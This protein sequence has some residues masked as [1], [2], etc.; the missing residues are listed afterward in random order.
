VFGAATGGEVFVRMAERALE[1]LGK[2]TP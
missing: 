2:A 1:H